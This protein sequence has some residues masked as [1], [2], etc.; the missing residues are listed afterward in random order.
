MYRTGD[1]VR[2]RADGKLDFLGRADG[3]VKLRGYRIELGEIEAAL[4]AQPHVTQAVVLKREDKPGDLR[5]VAYVTGGADAAALRQAL[6][7]QL[8]EHMVPAR[9]PQPAA[10]AL[11]AAD[12]G[13]VER[14]A[15]VQCGIEPCGIA[16]EFRDQQ[17]HRHPRRSL[18]PVN[19]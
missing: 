9:C 11:S 19:A 17:A 8:P 6:T 16:Q 14:M 1:L 7:G 18:T 3:Q 4:E 13:H 5:L 12:L 2:R 15:H 10:L